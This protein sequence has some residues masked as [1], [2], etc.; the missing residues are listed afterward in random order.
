MAYAAAGLAGL[1]GVL[2][3]LR[4]PRVLRQRQALAAELRKSQFPLGDSSLRGLDGWPGI[5]LDV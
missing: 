1:G 5:C 2:D 4:A 3:R